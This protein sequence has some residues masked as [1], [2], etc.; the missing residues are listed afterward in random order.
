MLF[1]SP[2]SVAKKLSVGMEVQVSPDFAPREEYGYMQGL[3]TSIGTY[4]VTQDEVNS[5]IGG[6]QIQNNLLPGDSA[7]EVRINLTVDPDSADL[8]KWSNKK[9]EKIQVSIGTGC[10]ILIVVKKQRPIELILG[11]IEGA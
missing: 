7:I 4:P 2:A 8:I 5:A 3:I 6:M 10:N 11:G 9:G 1:R